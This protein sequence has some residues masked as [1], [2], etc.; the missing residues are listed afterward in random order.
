MRF[1]FFLTT[2][3]IVFVG[4][5]SWAS[6]GVA[7][8]G[9]RVVNGV[10]MMAPIGSSDEI[11]SLP[12]R[13]RRT[14]TVHFLTASDHDLLSRAFDAADKDDW[15][16]AQGLAYQ[17]TDP[18]GRTL[19][20]WRYLVDKNTTASFSEIDQFLRAHPDWPLHD[21][22]LSRA[23]MAMTEDMGPSIIVGWYGSRAPNTGTGKVKL[24]NALIAMGRTSD[25]RQMIRSA[26]LENSLSA[27]EQLSVIRDHGD[28]L[29]LD[30]QR[31]E[32]LI[33]RDDVANAKRQIARV[34]DDAQRIAEARL[35]L[36]SNPTAGLRM[37]NM[38][39]ASLSNDAGLLFD[40][41]HV[42]RQRGNTEEA[43]AL[44]VRAAQVASR[45]YPGKWWSELNLAA[46]QAIE[47]GRYQSAYMLVS[48]TGLTSGSDFA[49]AEFLAGWIALELLKQPSLALPHFRKLEGGVTRPIS[50][51]RA[52]Y[53][54]GRT[55]E[56]LGDQALAAQCYTRA[57]QASDTFYGQL[58]LAKLSA[59]PVLH[60]H[61]A[62]IDPAPLRAD[63][64]RRDVIHAIRV[65]ADLGEVSLLR[66]FA[67]ATIE[68]VPDPR[69]VALLAE[70]LTQYGYP[71][72]A[73]RVAKSAGYNNVLLLAYSHPTIP[74]PSYTGP[75]TPPEPPLVL[76]LIRQET[77]FDSSAVSHSGAMGIMQLM[78]AS[79]QRMAALSNLD[80]RP[81]S[82][83]YDSQYNM[84]LGMALMQR[85]VS[86]WGGSYVLAIASYNAGPGNVRKWIAAH[87]DPRS[88]TVDP[89]DWIELI[90]FSETRNYV[91]RVL[92]NT[93][94]YRNRMAGGDQPL[95][96]MQD[97]YRP[98]L[99][100][101]KLV[102]YIPPAA[103]Q[104]ATAAS[105]PP[106]DASPKRKRHSLFGN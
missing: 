73:V 48:N 6:N 49:D 56:A 30:R 98:N 23:E 31:L 42:Q 104:S 61:D 102:Q 25:G 28:I 20:E 60:L 9:I 3:A 13:E 103:T 99:P 59:A 101:V 67:L 64:E 47:Q 65:L 80:Y 91:Q 79:A 90:P 70:M 45:A 88:P 5:L 44:F 38:L 63:F 17:A 43:A 89:I 46:R 37:A 94:V 8:T 53:W 87:G 66:T 15:S 74:V 105:T 1:S 62:G 29:T 106:A 32:A 55:Y 40:E 52:F 97:V 93:E 77:E 34:P 39:S 36:R 24:G 16:G 75:G 11:A 83:L 71:E 41:A 21:A 4:L 35:T 10:M 86:D 96:I 58:S 18:I 50:R 92:E 84:Q 33:W 26:W 22:L 82:V 95:K 76:G 81:S 51:A 19:I 57:A 2:A 7:Q 27:T 100:P 68:Q 72:I 12:K 78:P 69:H 14:S 85:E 54:E